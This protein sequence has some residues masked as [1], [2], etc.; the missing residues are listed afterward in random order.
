MLNLMLHLSQ[1]TAE[2]DPEDLPARRATQTAATAELNNREAALR[3]SNRRRRRHRIH[4][5]REF[6]DRR[7]P[8]PAL[9]GASLAKIDLRHLTLNDLGQVDGRDGV[10]DRALERVGHRNTSKTR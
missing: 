6:E 3:A 5:V 9:R 10:A 8:R 7:I 4:G 2:G 1:Q